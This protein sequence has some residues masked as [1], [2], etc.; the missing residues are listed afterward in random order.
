MNGDLVSLCVTSYN[1]PKL[2]KECVESFFKTNL[3]D[4]NNLELIIIDNGST[5]IEVT[6]YI[7]NLEPNCRNY[8][9]ILNEKNDYPVCLKYAKV[10]ARNEAKGDYFIDCPDDHLFVV[11]T[12]WIEECVQHIDEAKNAGCLIYFSYPLY[13]FR[14]ANNAMAPHKLNKN[15]Y[16]SLHKGYADYHIMSKKAY[17]KIGDFKYELEINFKTE[18]DYMKRALDAGYHRNMLKYPVAI[19]N[20]NCSAEAGWKDAGGF[21]LLEPFKIDEITNAFK[22][23]NRPVCNE[24]LILHCLN[25]K[26]IDKMEN[27][28]RPY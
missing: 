24:E 16:E 13:R 20:D 12:N 4:L 5:N 3:Y 18:R 26:R 14:K 1:R 19:I 23:L 22:I 7:K 28:Q 9:F 25:N 27:Y 8:T 6:D 17:E 10:Q 2:L 15:I 21:K 11:K